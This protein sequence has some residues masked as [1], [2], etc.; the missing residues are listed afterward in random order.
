MKIIS[1][2]S[3]LLVTSSLLFSCNS[4]NGNPPKTDNHE[5]IQ[6]AEWLLGRWENTDE[7]GTLSETWEKDSDSSFAGA[8]YFVSGD[9]TL[10]SESIRLVEMDGGLHYIPTVSDQNEG[11]PV[12]F[13]LI[14]GTATQLIFEN[15]KHDFPQN[16]R[17]THTNDSLIAVI[18]GKQKGKPHQEVFAMKRSEN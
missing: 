14:H 11:E 10:F 4:L 5:L 1:F 7:Q 9:D 3:A 18:S 16:I 12:D 2:L 6:S 13:T 15:R 17:Y 8:S